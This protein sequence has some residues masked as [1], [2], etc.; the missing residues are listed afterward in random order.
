MRLQQTSEV[1]PAKIRIFLKLSGREFQS[2]GPAT[3]KA[4]G[5]SVLSRHR[6]TTKRRRV[7]D[8]SCCRA[9]TSDTCIQMSVRYRGD[10]PCRQHCTLRRRVCTEHWTMYSASWRNVMSDVVLFLLTYHTSCYL[11]CITAAC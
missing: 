5:P 11:V 1:V 3:E 7:A 4:C 2:D 8:R 10:W 6:G 9:E